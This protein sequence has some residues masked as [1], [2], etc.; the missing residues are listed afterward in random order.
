MGAD[1][2]FIKKNKN[3]KNKQTKNFFFLFKM[4]LRNNG[5]TAGMIYT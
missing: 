4:P 3:K 2:G 1:P 5:I